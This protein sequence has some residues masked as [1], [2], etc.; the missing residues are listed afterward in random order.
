MISEAEH[1]SCDVYSQVCR[2]TPNIYQ[3]ISTSIDQTH[4]RA[5]GAAD[6][7]DEEEYCHAD[8]DQ[9]AATAPSHRDRW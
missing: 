4:V 2:E 1:T 8:S 6:E 9:T 3:S 7:D 5:D